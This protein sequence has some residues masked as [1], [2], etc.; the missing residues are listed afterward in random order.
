MQYAPKQQAEFKPKQ[1]SVKK[2][3]TG[4][5]PSHF[6]KYRP[7]QYKAK[8]S[9]EALTQ[10]QPKNTDSTCSSSSP[11]DGTNSNSSVE[12]ENKQT[13]TVLATSFSQQH[14][15]SIDATSFEGGEAEIL[16]SDND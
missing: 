15:M 8:F 5:R 13:T 6:G 4:S 14:K 12:R 2:G 3:N 11:S 16:S 9:K 1:N 7:V 10:Y